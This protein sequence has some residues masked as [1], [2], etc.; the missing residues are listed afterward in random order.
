MR[1]DFVAL[2]NA[3]YAAWLADRPA[4]IAIN[5]EEAGEIPVATIT[6]TIEEPVEETVEVFP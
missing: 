4:R 5:A 1:D 2:V 6:Q 3:R